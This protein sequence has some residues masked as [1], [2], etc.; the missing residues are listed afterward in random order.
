MPQ[1]RLATIACMPYGAM[2]ATIM[3]QHNNPTYDIVVIDILQSEI[4]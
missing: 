1:T 4:I 2:V 3:V